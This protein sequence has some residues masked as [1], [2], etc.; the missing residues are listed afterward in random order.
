MFTCG[1]R[2]VRA[3]RWPP[4]PQM[5]VHLVINGNPGFAGSPGA[6]LLIRT[7]H[8]RHTLFCVLNCEHGAEDL[9]W[10]KLCVMCSTTARTEPLAGAR[11]VHTESVSERQTQAVSTHVVHLYY[12]TP[13]PLCP[14]RGAALY[15]PLAA[16]SAAAGP[17]MCHDD[18]RETKSK[19]GDL[20]VAVQ[21]HR[22]GQA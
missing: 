8:T 5:R 14:Q 7:S 21:L 2:E 17:C 18:G 16:R 10:H 22:T 20:P 9:F 19:N 3:C 13:L 12:F 1:R 15:Y 4:V 6:R 11:T